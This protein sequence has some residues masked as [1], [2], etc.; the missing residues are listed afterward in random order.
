MTMATLTTMVPGFLRPAPDSMVAY[1]RRIGNK[2]WV[3]ALNVM[4]SIWVFLTPLFTPV[5]ASFWWSLVLSY[6]VF[7]LLFTLV[8][9]RP[10]AETTIYASLLAV[11][12]CVSMPWNSTAWTYGVFACVY[13]PYFGSLRAS[14]LKIAMIQLVMLVVA[15]WQQWPWFIMA[16]LVGVCTSSGFGS[17][18]GRMH[19][20][21]N[22]EQRLS[23]EEVRRLA[24]VAERERIGRDLHDLLGHTLSLI[25]M[26]LE[27]SRKLFDRDHEAARRELCEAEHV[28]RHALA[29]VR[30]AVSGIR[31]TDLVA[32]VASA[33]L[34]LEPAGVRLECPRAMPTLPED[35][36]RAL[37]LIVREAVTNVARHAHAT[38]V[39]L[40][41]VVGGGNVELRV[42]DDGRG[43]GGEEG[44]GLRGMRER[45]RALGGVLRLDAPRG[46]GTTLHVMVP[47]PATKPL[48]SPQTGT[49]MQA[50][51]TSAPSRAGIAGERA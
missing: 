8:H 12:A 10:Y 1:L 2:P 50:D 36:E 39:E 31:A 40:D 33:R 14:T 45:V 19:L 17:L 43:G 46:R 22:A 28:A 9:V 42:A 47:L 7:L 44:N 30:S 21:K 26:K 3:Q 35:I 38:H 41:L 25:T 23:H 11:L 16:L 48:Q 18:M 34:M 15:F 13:V 51:G 27:L 5:D 49:E 37:A 6:P 20:I 24:A 32:E 29:E 4:W